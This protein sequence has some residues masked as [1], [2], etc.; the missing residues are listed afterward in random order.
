MGCKLLTDIGIYS[1]WWKCFRTRQRWYLRKMVA[2]LNATELFT[3]KWLALCYVNSTSLEK[4]TEWK[5]PDQKNKKKNINYNSVYIKFWKMEMYLYWQRDVCLPEDCGVRWV[6]RDGWHRH[7]RNLSGNGYPW[8]CVHVNTHQIAHLK[9]CGLL[10][11]TYVSVKAMIKAWCYGLLVS[12]GEN[13]VYH[14]CVQVGGSWMCAHRSAMMPTAGLY[15]AL[16][17]YW[18]LQA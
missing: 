15:L 4:Q 12:S 13:I 14:H 1:G 2:A 10:S 11:V 8:V 3:S 16:A 17:A 18:A 6:Q 9:M 7:M 5:K